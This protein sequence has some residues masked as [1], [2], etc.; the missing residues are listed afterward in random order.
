MISEINDDFYIYVESEDT[1]SFIKTSF[2]KESESKPNKRIDLKIFLSPEN[3]DNNM[4]IILPLDRKCIKELS[5]MLNEVNK[6]L[7]SKK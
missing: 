4:E 7:E 2:I 5:S 6:L 1:E 3:K